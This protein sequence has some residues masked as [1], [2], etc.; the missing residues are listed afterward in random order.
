MLE[1][2]AASA[3]GGI[4]CMDRIFLQSQVSRPVVAGTIM[5][6]V[7]K[8]PMAGL[9]AGALVELFWIDQSQIG[10]YI[11][12]ND[13]VVAIILTTSTIH[14][15]RMLGNLSDELMTLAFLLCIPMGLLSRKIDETIMRANDGLSRKALE[16]AVEGDVRGI[17]MKQYF[18][19][20]RYYLT[21]TVFLMAFAWSMTQVLILTYPAVPAKFLPSLAY[22]H[23]FLPLLGIAVALN[24]IH[25]R[26]VMPVFCGI[27]M[28]LAVFLKLF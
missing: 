13:S 4:L 27:F 21:S 22:I 8:N 1:T 11:P 16:N 3:I 17:E 23:T 6:V 18:G 24:T 20:V 14:S 9:M 19:V 10:T 15:G 2:L 26:G 7:L 28:T 25:L 5:G 12:P